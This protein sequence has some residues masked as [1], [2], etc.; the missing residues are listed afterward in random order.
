MRRK[1]TRPEWRELGQAVR[2]ARLALPGAPSQ[3]EIARRAGLSAGILSQVERGLQGL[4]LDSAI[5]LSAALGVDRDRLYALCGSRR[6]TGHD[7]A[8]STMIVLRPADPTA[9]LREV[10]GI[11]LRAGWRGELVSAVLR[12][13]HLTRPEPSA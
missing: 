8:D 12:L 10:E 13:L 11:L 1:T 9:A 5:R 2:E 4:S 7:V 6:L 3:A